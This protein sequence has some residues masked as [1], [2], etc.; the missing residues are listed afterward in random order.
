[1][2]SHIC[3]GNKKLGLEFAFANLSFICMVIFHNKVTLDAGSLESYLFYLLSAYTISVYLTIALCNPG[4]LTL[5]QK[6]LINIKVRFHSLFP[7]G[8]N[9]ATNY[10]R[11][12][13]MPIFYFI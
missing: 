6:A 4:R 10:K 9:Y 11:L 12:I 7:L 3:I 2:N 1:M 5:E 8:L 13:F